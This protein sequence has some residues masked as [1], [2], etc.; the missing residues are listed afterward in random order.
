MTVR[1]GHAPLVKKLLASGADK[2]ITNKAGKDAEALAIEYGKQDIA[3]SLAS[4]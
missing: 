4:A 2:T 1:F 3:A